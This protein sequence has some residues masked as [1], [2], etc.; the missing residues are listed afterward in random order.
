MISS[1][2]RH[3][4]RM[5]TRVKLLPMAQRAMVRQTTPTVLNGMR[6]FSVDAASAAATGEKGTVTKTLQ[7]LDMAVVRQIKAELMEV[8][9]NS[10]GRQ[11]P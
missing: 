8:D 3:A 1:T 9:A 10:D 5:T 4:G 7:A 6:N 11:V 2:A